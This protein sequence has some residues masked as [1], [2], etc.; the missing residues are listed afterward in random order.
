[1]YSEFSQYLYLCYID[2]QTAYDSVWRIGLWRIM[3][4]LGFEYKLVRTLEALYE[5]TMSV[6]RGVGGLSEW[7]TLLLEL[8]KDESYRR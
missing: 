1:M 5:H 8:C 3:R 2:F 7:L 6:V 4:F